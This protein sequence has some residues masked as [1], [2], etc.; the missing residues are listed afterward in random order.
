MWYFIVLRLQKNR[1]IFSWLSSFINLIT[2]VLHAMIDFIVLWLQKNRIIF[3]WFRSFFNLVTGVCA[4]IPDVAE[5]VVKI[6]I[7]AA[8]MFSTVH[9]CGLRPSWICDVSVKLKVNWTVEMRAV[10]KIFHG[11]KYSYFA[12]CISVVF[13]IWFRYGSL[14]FLHEWS[15]LV[16]ICGLQTTWQYHERTFFSLLLVVLLAGYFWVACS[17]SLLQLCT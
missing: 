17:R 16:R 9:G 8:F 12:V 4:Y 10:E 6:F 5:C 1:I 2:G 7:L 11:I 15:A 14:H 3:S 13:C